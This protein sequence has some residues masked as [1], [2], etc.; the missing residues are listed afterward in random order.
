MVWRWLSFWV[1][2]HFQGQT[3]SFREAMV[4]KIGVEIPRHG[5]PKLCFDKRPKKV[6]SMICL[7]FSLQTLGGKWIELDEHVFSN[8]L[9]PPHRKLSLLPATGNIHFQMVVSIG[10]FQIITWK[11]VVSSN[12]TLKKNWWFGVPGL[13]CFL[14]KVSS[15]FHP[16]PPP[17]KKQPEKLAKN[18]H[19]SF[20]RRELRNLNWSK[21]KQNISTLVFQPIMSQGCTP[22][23]SL[24]LFS[25][26]NQH[27]THH[28]SDG[29]LDDLF[30]FFNFG[31]LI[32]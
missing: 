12:I 15:H 1:S 3:V 2:A 18:I 11:M 16:P 20:P 7:E 23:C 22:P 32:I 17:K 5:I 24:D 13:F 14:G 26:Q 8:G 28:K 4:R 27:E 31:Q 9:K 30:C 21:G 29:N 6:V 25:M 10:R 19:P